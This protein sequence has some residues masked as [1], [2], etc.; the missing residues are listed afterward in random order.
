M[1]NELTE[2]F[3][4]SEYTNFRTLLSDIRLYEAVWMMK[5]NPEYRIDAISTD[6]GPNPRSLAFLLTRLL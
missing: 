4:Q 3:N 5:S 6:C 2:Y 1:K